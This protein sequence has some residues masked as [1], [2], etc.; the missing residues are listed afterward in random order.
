M[1]P[2]LVL[3]YCFIRNEQD[4]DI[5]TLLVGRVYPTRTFFA[6][7]VDVKGRDSNAVAKLGDFIKANGLT[8]F[9]Y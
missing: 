8:K 7:P 9:V 2:L 1:V 3:D 5:L 6:C 4:E